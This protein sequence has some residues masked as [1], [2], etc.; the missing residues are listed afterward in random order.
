MGAVFIM[1][2]CRFSSAGMPH[3]QDQ[4][5][6]R[7]GQ[8]PGVVILQGIWQQWPSMGARRKSG[9][10]CISAEPPKLECGHSK[11]TSKSSIQFHTSP[12][13]DRLVV[14]NRKELL[15]NKSELRSILHAQDI[16]SHSTQCAQKLNSQGTYSA[17]LKSMS[18]LGL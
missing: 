4:K 6:S 10:L 14:A 2:C 16:N 7:S 13:P 9:T 12:K 11:N 3:R 15:S 8:L 5:P 1:I 17:T 18:S